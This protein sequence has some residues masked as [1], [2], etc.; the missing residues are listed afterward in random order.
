MVAHR[1]GAIASLRPD[2][3]TPRRQR[4]RMIDARLRKRTASATDHALH[5]FKSLLA[6]NAVI[7]A[8]RFT[9]ARQGSHSRLYRQPYVDE[10]LLG[11]CN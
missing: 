8:I 10:C 2:R 1:S 4:R 3:G 5:L 11:C 7:G 9:G 6:G